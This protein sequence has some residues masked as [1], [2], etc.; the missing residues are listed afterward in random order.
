MRLI[1][2]AFRDALWTK[3]LNRLRVSLPGVDDP[4]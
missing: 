1:G 3:F 2:H 4:S